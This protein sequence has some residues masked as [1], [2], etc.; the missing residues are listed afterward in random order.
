MV[1]RRVKCFGVV[2]KTPPYP[3]LGQGQNW[4]QGYNYW[5]H[6]YNQNY[7][8]GQQGYGY[9]SGYGHYDYPYYSYGGGHDYSKR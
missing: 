8:Y 6:G 3:F 1:C 5:H 2:M 9:G 4:N 7:G